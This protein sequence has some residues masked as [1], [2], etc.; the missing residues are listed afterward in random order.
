MRKTEEAECKAELSFLAS[1][2]R[3]AGAAKRH[4]WE[5]LSCC[6]TETHTKTDMLDAYSYT[7]RLVRL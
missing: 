6:V 7:F 3:D 1:L 5:E 2:V 4:R